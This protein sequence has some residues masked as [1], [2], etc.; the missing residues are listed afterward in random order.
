VLFSCAGQRLLV[1]HEAVS[2]SKQHALL[3]ASEKHL[4]L[5]LLLVHNYRCLNG[6]DRSFGSKPD[7]IL[8]RYQPDP[9]RPALHHARAGPTAGPC[10]GHPLGTTC[11]ARPGPFKQR[12]TTLA[13]NL[14][15]PIQSPV[16]SPPHP[17]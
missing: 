6:T 12:S 15:Y 5:Y 13:R 17:P 4:P 7:T 9:T 8:T 16:P 10:M 3:L 2:F 1:R 14:P 11:L